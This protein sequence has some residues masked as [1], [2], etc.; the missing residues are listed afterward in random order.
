M[1]NISDIMENNMQK[2]NIFSNIAC[3]IMSYLLS[4]MCCGFLYIR[5]NEV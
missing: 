1:L 2:S 4:Y 5:P 3:K